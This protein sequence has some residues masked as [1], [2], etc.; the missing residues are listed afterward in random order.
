MSQSFPYFAFV[1]ISINNV[2]Y[3]SDVAL[4]FLA[5]PKLTPSWLWLL[6]EGNINEVSFYSQLLQFPPLISKLFVVS[7]AECYNFTFPPSNIKLIF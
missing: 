1:A 4:K 3:Y 5:R 6:T 2:L 7:G